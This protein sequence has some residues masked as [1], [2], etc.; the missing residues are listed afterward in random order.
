M[1]KLAAFR[2]T[3][4]SLKWLKEHAKKQGLS[5]T[6]VVQTFINNAIQKETQTEQT[7][8]TAPSAATHPTQL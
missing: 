8:G 7:I 1:K 6:A 2:L 4:T 5:Q 3:E